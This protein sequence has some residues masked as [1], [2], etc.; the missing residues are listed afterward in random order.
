MGDA[1]RRAICG[2]VLR[3]MNPDDR[4]AARAAAIVDVARSVRAVHPA[5]PG[6]PFFGIDHAGATPLELVDELA[7]RGIFRKYEHVLDLGGGLGATTR[8]MT[9]RLGCTATATARTQAESAAGRLLTQRA[10]L[11]WQVFH[12][13]ADATRLPFAEA[14]FT[15][16]W[17]VDALPSLGA[18]DAVLAE[19]FRVLRPGGHLGVQDLVATTRRARHARVDATTRRAELGRAGFLEIVCRDVAIR[20]DPAQGRAAWEQL[21]RRVGPDDDYVRRREE[22]DVALTSGTLAVVQLTGRRP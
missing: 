6:R 4:W 11:D 16:V 18:T 3:R 7:T 21:V 8:Y 17:I 14:A 15:H 19:A 12:A 5:P 13:V 9:A 1:R 20:A 2:S 10:G 22:L